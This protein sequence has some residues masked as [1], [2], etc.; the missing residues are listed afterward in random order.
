MEV[1]FQKVSSTHSENYDS[2]CLLA[3]AYYGYT[4]QGTYLQIELK[5]VLVQ[6]NNV[7]YVSFAM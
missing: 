6:N 7:D 2:V 5:S 3:K 4:D 1:I